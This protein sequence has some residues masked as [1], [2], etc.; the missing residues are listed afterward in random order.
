MPP[1]SLSP[2][3]DFAFALAERWLIACVMMTVIGV[4]SLASV[5]LALLVFRLI[6]LCFGSH[7][8]DET[9]R[10]LC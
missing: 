8:V 10:L 3:V 9:I 7:G 1:S 6:G 2:V 4:V 5:Q